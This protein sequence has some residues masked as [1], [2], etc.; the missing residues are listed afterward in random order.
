MLVDDV[1]A[2]LE[3]NTAAEDRVYALVLPKATS[4]PAITY[5]V[6]SNSPTTSL[7]GSRKPDRVR[8]QVD[9]WAKTYGAAMS[10]L[11]QVRPLMAAAGFQGVADNAF[12]D[13][14]EESEL[15]RVSQDFFCWDR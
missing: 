3:D 1:L 12:D 8:V 4:Y 5:Q 7:K 13:F 14:E 10:L 9:C 11:A 2:A 6:I 15:Y